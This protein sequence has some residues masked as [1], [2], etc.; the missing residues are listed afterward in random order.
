MDVNIFDY[1]SQM[2]KTIKKATEAQEELF[3]IRLMGM[4]D[5][6]DQM[7]RTLARMHGNN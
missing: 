1:F 4:V 5:R 2:E 6:L 7:E 3:E